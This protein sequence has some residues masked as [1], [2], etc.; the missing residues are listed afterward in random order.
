MSALRLRQKL[1]GLRGTAPVGVVEAS[2]NAP[3]QAP[4]PIEMPVRLFP[5]VN[6][7]N[8]DLVGYAN[9]P[10]EDGA[11]Q[12]VIISFTVP[13]GRNG[14]IRKIANNYVGGGWVEGSGAVIWKILV[15][16]GPIPGASSYSS[17]PASLGSPANPVEIA[18]FRIF[19][20]QTITLIAINVGV[21]VA[22]QLVGGRLVGYLYPRELDDGDI[23]V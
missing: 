18:G 3:A 12:A 23:W 5:P 14:I 16:N 8:L 11:T 1:F 10:V 4:Q 13:I 9:L 22:G 6:W 2:A 21:A 15:D 17:I 20:N 7:E 19:E